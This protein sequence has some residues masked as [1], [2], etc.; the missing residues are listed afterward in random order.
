MDLKLKHGMR[1]PDCL[2]FFVHRE[3]NPNAITVQEFH[4][5]TRDSIF[6]IFDIQEAT[7]T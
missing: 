6:T 2:W 5:E 3:E 7:K 1:M 4:A